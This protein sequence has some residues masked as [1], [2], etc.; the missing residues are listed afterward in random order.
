MKLI[1]F[2]TPDYVI[3]VLDALK[4]AEYEIA[5]VVTQPPK[6]AG[7]KGVLTPSPVSLWTK[8][9]G[10]KVFDGKPR[11]I[12]EDLKKLGA[13]VGVLGA[14]GRILPPE[15]LTIFPHGILNIHPSLLPKYRGASP[16]QAV[17]AAGEKQTGITI[18]KLDSE[19]DHGPLVTQFTEDIRKDDTAGSLRERLFKKAADELVK[20][21]PLYLQRLAVRQAGLPAGKAGRTEL[22]EQEH[23]KATYTTLLK[24]EHGFIPPKYIAAA[25]KGDAFRGWKRRGW[26]IPF[27]KDYRLLPSARCLERFIRALDPWP[28]A[29]TW[30]K[31]KVTGNTA[32]V[33]RRLKILKAH[34]EKKRVTNNELRVTL[35]PDLVQLE[36]KNPVSWEEFKKGYPGAKFE[37]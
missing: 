37:N 16:V 1:F 30:T 3:P 14:Y 28:G 8:K 19:I 25:L 32:Q 29:W 24:K 20:T 36:G 10:I 9:H 2:G 23:E 21:L 4:K 31:I 13:E 22:K 17:I 18:I 5:A 26:Q 27:I 11:E 12:A 7:R 35:V 6:L 33:T 34:V 15:I